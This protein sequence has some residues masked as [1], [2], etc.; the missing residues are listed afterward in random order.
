M[1][2][3]AQVLRGARAPLVGPGD[4]LTSGPPV[5]MWSTAPPSLVVLVRP[6]RTP[7]AWARVS[8][9]AQQA[10]SHLPGGPDSWDTL[11]HLPLVGSFV[12][13]LLMP[14]FVHGGTPQ[15]YRVRLLPPTPAARRAG[16]AL[17]CD[18]TV[19]LDNLH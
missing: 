16:C 2:T 13:Q 5:P 1:Q 9:M 3:A 7:L 19:L 14:G 10:A 8:D 11:A 18:D 12:E 17:A 4:L 15:L 6:R